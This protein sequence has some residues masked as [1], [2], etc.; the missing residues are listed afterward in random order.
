M[1]RRSGSENPSFSLPQ[2]LFEVD[3]YDELDDDDDNVLS[4]LAIDYGTIQAAVTWTMLRPLSLFSS[5]VQRNRLP[6]KLNSPGSY[7][8]PAGVI[9][10]Y[11]SMLW[12]ARQ[13][14]ETWVIVI[15]LLTCAFQHLTARVFMSE[16]KFGLHLT[17]LG[18]C[19]FPLLLVAVFVLLVRPPIVVSAAIEFHGV[20][21]ATAASYGA[22]YDLCCSESE[23]DKRRIML[24]WPALLMNVYF[25]SLLPSG[26]EE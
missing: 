5:S 17:V 23:A 25:V 7:V 20:L 15:F 1:R 26:A 12:L 14:N 8:G 13:P 22:Y 21:W 19:A 4:D 2:W 3:E 11:A 6:V 16:S 24:L 18:F 10:V 9:G